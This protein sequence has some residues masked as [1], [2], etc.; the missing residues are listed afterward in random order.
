MAKKNCQPYE[1]IHTKSDIYALTES[2]LKTKAVAIE[3]IDCGEVN[4]VYSVQVKRNDE[5]VLKISPQERK[6]NNLLQEAWAFNKCRS[7]GVP[8]PEVISV[9]TSLNTFPEAYLLT[10]KIPGTSGDEMK[11]TD[12][13]VIDLMHQIGHY[14]HLIHSI[15]IDGF[16]EIKQTE[17]QFRGMHSTLWQSI[18]SDFESS[19]WVEVLTTHKLISKKDLE[20]YQRVLEKHK[21]LFDL[22]IALLTHGDIGT[23]NL[24]MKGNKI[25]GIVDMENVL[26]TDPVRDFHWFGYWIEDSKRLKALQEG[27][28]NKELFDNNFPLKMRLYQIIHSFP[29]LAYYQSRNNYPALKYLQGKV[30]EADQFLGL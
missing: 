4:D 29:A 3:K 25:V 8:T 28:D 22:K 13:E 23:R 18:I 1:S 19:W 20:K 24:I 16:G 6:K 12:E 21:N 9:D 17:N 15:Q 5:Y 27:Y 14:L 26:A 11:F 7:V 2:V 30:R 10:K